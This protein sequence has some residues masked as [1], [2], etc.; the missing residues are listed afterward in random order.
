[1]Y[2]MRMLSLSSAIDR[3]NQRS[4]NAV[5]LHMHV[6]KVNSMETLSHICKRESR[7]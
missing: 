5:H 7:M 2:E 6:G 1:M 3:R 4:T